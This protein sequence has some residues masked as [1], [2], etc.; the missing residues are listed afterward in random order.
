MNKKKNTKGS[1]LAYSLIVLAIMFAI[2]GSLSSVTALQK[3][4]AGAS[5]ASSQ[6]FQVA[7]SGVQIAIN[8]INK[9]IKTQNNKLANAFPGE[10]NDAGGLATVINQLDAAGTMKYELSFS[11]A[12]GTPLASCNDLVTAVGNVKATGTYKTTIRAVEVSIGTT[13][14]YTKL[15]IHADGP[16]NSIDIADFSSPAKTVTSKNGARIST[17][18]RMFGDGGSVFFDGTDDYL[19]VSSSNDWNFGKGDFTV[20]FWEKNGTTNT[21]QHALSFGTGA[22]ANLDFDFNDFNSSCDGSKKGLW[23]YWNSGG[24]K[25]ICVGN[26]NDYTDNQWHHIA[27]VRYNGVITLYIDGEP[28]GTTNYNI[29]IDLSSAAVNSIG[30]EKSGTYF[31]NGYLDEIRISKGVARWTSDFSDRLPSAPY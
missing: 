25:K 15:L 23:V 6:A 21:R 17:S 5:Q 9:V 19:T 11:E 28:K 31:W 3:K 26:T 10:C 14:S 13:D 18:E 24:N 12:G 2:M 4:G 16:N 22:T 30:A 7:D 29:D 27:L 8:K 1:I 20:D